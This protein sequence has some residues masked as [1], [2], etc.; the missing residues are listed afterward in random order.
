MKLFRL[1]PAAA[2]V[3]LLT[4][5]EEPDNMAY[6]TALGINKSDEGYYYTIQFAQPT[7][8]SGGASEKGGSGGNIVK[9]MTVEAPTL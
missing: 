4:A 7:Q 2:L 6:I 5:C 9:N 8:I 1:L 3:M